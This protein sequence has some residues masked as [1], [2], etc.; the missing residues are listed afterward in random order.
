MTQ[1]LMSDDMYGQVLAYSGGLGQLLSSQSRLQT[2]LNAV[3]QKTSTPYGFQILENFTELTS[4]D[5]WEMSNGDWSTNMLWSKA[6]TNLT[7]ILDPTKK[8]VDNY[9]T[10]LNDQWNPV[11]IYLKKN[12]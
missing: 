7:Y 12:G 2:H 5:L 8:M 6:S 4:E 1:S 11:G 9:R 10:R 3:Y